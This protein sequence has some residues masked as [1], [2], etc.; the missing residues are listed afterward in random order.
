MVSEDPSAQ[1]RQILAELND[2]HGTEITRA[3]G[4]YEALHAAGATVDELSVA[5]GELLRMAPMPVIIIAAGQL[6]LC[7]RMA[8]PS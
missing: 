5:A 3:K 6:M 7:K 4:R 2:R 8:V 1:R